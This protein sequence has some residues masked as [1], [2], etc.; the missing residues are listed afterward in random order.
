MTLAVIVMCFFSTTLYAARQSNKN[1]KGKASYYSQKA[2]GARMSN[3][4]K[5]HPDS[6]TCAH[7]TH[8]FGTKLLVKNPVNGKQVVVTVT[9]RGPHTRGR[10]IDLSYAAAKQLDILRAGVA[11]VE[12]SVYVP[13]Q[14]VPYRLDKKPEVEL[15]FIVDFLDENP[16]PEPIMIVPSPAKQKGSDTAPAKQKNSDT[17]NNK[18][19]NETDKD[20]SIGQ[21]PPMQ[22]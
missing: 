8:P 9:D 6:L 2:K 20:C 3:G 22:H 5:Y 15:D 11:P 21:R 12:V 7:K 1:Q 16:L 13:E 17:N 14:Q 18:T 4:T 19:T 10:I